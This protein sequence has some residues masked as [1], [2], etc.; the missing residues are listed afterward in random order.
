[1]EKRYYELIV[2]LI[3]DHRRF[4][5]CESI[6]DEIIDDIYQHAE[7]VFDSI[8]D[9]QVLKQYLNKVVSTSNSISPTI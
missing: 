9:E 8:T 6:L 5:G 2:S 1:M 3:K 4:Q 7:V